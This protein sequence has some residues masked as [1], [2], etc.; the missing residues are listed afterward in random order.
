M[1]CLS[2]VFLA[3]IVPFAER[4]AAAAEYPEE[5][6]QRPQTLPEKMV[7]LRSGAALDLSAGRPVTPEVDV[8]FRWGVTDAF[9]LGLH[10]VF[11]S[12]SESLVTGQ[13]LTARGIVWH[14]DC[15]SISLVGGATLMRFAESRYH[16][17]AA[18]GMDLNVRGGERFAFRAGSRYLSPLSNRDAFFDRY[19]A[20]IEPSVNIVPSVALLLRV[21][22]ALAP[23]A[24]EARAGFSLS[25]LYTLDTRF[26]FGAS[27]AMPELVTQEGVRADARVVSA[28]VQWRLDGR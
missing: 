14:S 27:F 3:L 25:V 26:D 22:G 15:A 23:S 11:V 13:G 24:L 2:A 4:T 28:F 19:G 12:T 1:R 7:E 5:Y 6:T 21:D 20:Y 16:L 10:A 18:A 8:G 17:E 9:E